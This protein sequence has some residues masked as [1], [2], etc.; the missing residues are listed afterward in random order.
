MTGARSLAL[1]PLLSL[2]FIPPLASSPA[3]AADRP[4]PQALADSLDSPSL[5]PASLTGAIPARQP[6]ARSGSQFVSYVRAMDGAARERAIRAELLAGNIPSFLRDLKKVELPGGAAV[7]VMPD[8][9]AIGSDEDF[10]RFPASFETAS[11]V[12][13]RFGFVLPTTTIVDAIYDQAAL[14]LSPQTMTPG[15]EM[16]STAYFESHDG[17]IRSQLLGRPLGELVAG[18]KKDYVVTR[19]LAGALTQEAIYGWHRGVGSPIQPLS[20]VH[21]TRYADYSHG[22]RLVAETVYVG[23]QARSFYELLAT[24]QAGLISR[25]GAFPEARRLM[26]RWSPPGDSPSRELTLA[27]NREICSSGSPGGSSRGSSDPSPGCH[28]S[29]ELASGTSPRAP[30]SGRR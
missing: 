6:G 29:T 27:A 23:G 16:T 24:E 2:L 3:G 20:L 15:R 12:A 4:T 9:L 11:A 25:E 7:W 26:G 22:V 14:R 5:A 30:G 21:G 17:K 8:Y 1:A 19:R 28:A 10:V 18:H 13:R